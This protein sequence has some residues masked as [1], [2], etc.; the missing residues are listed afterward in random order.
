M[1]SSTELNL[2]VNLRPA[3]RARSEITLTT[4]RLVDPSTKLE[5]F[6]VRILRA[7]TTYQLT[8]RIVLRNITE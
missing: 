6:D 3:S 7:L 2:T 5:E 8:N 4:S 1:G